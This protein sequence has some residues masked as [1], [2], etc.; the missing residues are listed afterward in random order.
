MGWGLITTIVGYQSPCTASATTAKFSY[1]VAV[2]EQQ[3]R[4]EADIAVADANTIGLTAGSVLYY[5]MERYDPPIP[6]T[7]GCRAATIAFL[8]G[9]TERIHEPK[10][11]THSMSFTE[12]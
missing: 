10:V 3:G 4:G 12:P 5:D 1:D 7:L 6:D 2:A 8:K 11:T 9:C